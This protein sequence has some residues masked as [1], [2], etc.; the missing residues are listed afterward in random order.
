MDTRDGRSE[1]ELVRAAVRGPGARVLVGGLGVGFSLAEALALDPA[2]VTVVEIEPA[3]LRWNREHL[4]RAGAARRPAGHRRG[5]RPGRLPGPRPAASTTRSAST[6]TTVRSGRSQWTTPPCTAIRDCPQWTAGS[7][8]AARWRSGARTGPRTSRP[9]CAP[10]TAASSVDRDP[11]RPRRAGRRLGRPRP[12]GP[13]E[14]DPPAVAGSRG[15]RLA[16]LG[17]PWAAGRPGRG[18]P[19]GPCG[20]DRLR[21]RRLRPARADRQPPVPAERLERDLRARRV[22]PALVLGPVHQPD[23]LLDQRRVVPGRDQ[24]GPAEVAGR[25]SRPA[26]RRARRTAAASRC[27]AG[28]AAAPP[29]AAW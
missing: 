14:P 6:W 27:P 22:L 8:P 2:A 9:A 23:H 16:G 15:I 29:T 12:A 13:A 1:R 19:A 11:G 17:A 20:A 3:V 7:R 26:P 24:V 18:C 4:G 5:R 21:R 25:R 28:P 10:G